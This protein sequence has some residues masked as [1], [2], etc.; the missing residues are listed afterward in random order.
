MRVG[1]H[2]SLLKIETPHF[3]LKVK[4]AKDEGRLAKI[5]SDRKEVAV[6]LQ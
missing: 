1:E 5:S 6:R 2:Y 4:P 3:E